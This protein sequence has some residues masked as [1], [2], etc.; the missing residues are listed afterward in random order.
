MQGSSHPG[1][2]RQDK[3]GMTIVIRRASRWSGINHRKRH[4]VAVSATA[5][6]ASVAFA[7]TGFEPIPGVRGARLTIALDPPLPIVVPAAGQAP[8]LTGQVPG[9]PEGTTY[10][11][12]AAMQSGGTLTGSTRLTADPLMP[13]A[14][15]VPFSPGPAAPAL[16]F[17]SASAI[18][19]L[20]AS[21]CLTT[22][23][24]YEAASESDDGQRAVAQ[25]VLNRVRHPAY[26]GTVC[27][28]VF[29]GTDR[30]DRL[31]QFSFACD[32]AMA[33]MPSRTGW[34]RARR[35]AAEALAG[36]VFAP[37]GMATHYHTHAVN[38]VWNRSLV[39]TA[40]V[41]A[42][43]FFRFPGAGSDPAR[44]TG[45]YKGLE[46]FPGPLGAPRAAP[47]VQVAGAVP[48]LPLSDGPP[49]AATA[50]AIAPPVSVQPAFARSGDA[51]P[52]GR[53]D[54]AMDDQILP[55]YRDSGQWIGK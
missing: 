5:L 25:V 33:R 1:G 7:S 11:A 6:A 29:Q 23:I 34:A 12:L 31:C 52:G 22:A 48:V 53:L 4:I 21:V 43:M 51:V 18:D 2:W 8:V 44:F 36:H 49:R 16:P 38:P 9:M 13:H 30:G 37:V 28:V 26:P 55:K 50:V 19:N 54:A 14:G 35:I 24:Y 27:G 47:L 10:E 32:G 39:K 40:S 42:H 46:P 41:G 3:R 45:R 15:I 20:R 17:Q